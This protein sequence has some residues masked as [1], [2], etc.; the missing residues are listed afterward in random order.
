MRKKSLLFIAFALA[1]LMLAFYGCRDKQMTPAKQYVVEDFFRNPDKVNFSLSPD[2]LYY[3]YMAPYKG[4]MN[5]FVKEIGKEE[6]GQLTYDTL[7]SV[8]GFFWASNDRILYIKD[9]GGDEN[10]KLYGVNKDGSNLIALADF[11]KVRTEM[12][13]DLPDI[14]DYVIIGLNKRIPQVFD[15]YRLNINT[16][17]LTM[18]AENPGN[19]M[20]WMTDH[21]GSLRVAFAVVDGVNTSILYRDT[22]DEPFREIL[23]TTFKETHD[24]S[25]FH[26][27]Q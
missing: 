27:R 12:I 3:A 5:V 8:Y 19:I 14:D 10:M 20:G 18:L 21:N 15:P 11:E 25:V 17:E 1:A 7:R 13:D 24:A 6:A 4:M 16:G 22:E 9:Q 2:G 23:K 26:F